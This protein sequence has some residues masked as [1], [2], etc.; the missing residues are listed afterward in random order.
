MT[1]PPFHAL[2]TSAHKHQGPA[3]SRTPDVCFGSCYYHGTLN[4]SLLATPHKWLQHLF[5]PLSIQNLK[6]SCVINPIRE[7]K[8]PPAPFTQS[9]EADNWA[10][11]T[12]ERSVQHIIQLFWVSD[13]VWL[14][15]V[16]FSDL[17]IHPSGGRKA[18]I[19]YLPYREALT[20]TTHNIARTI[21]WLRL[22]N[23]DPRN[24]T[25]GKK[26]V[27]LWGGN[28]AVLF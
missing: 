4:C 8:G 16:T 20:V 18:S 5:S 6:R 19:S 9:E 3:C 12:R 23:E 22:H 28:A 14:W 7:H 21:D 24:V 15:L 1:G 13:S 11:G 2:K 27:W 25:A 10:I 26:F 17:F